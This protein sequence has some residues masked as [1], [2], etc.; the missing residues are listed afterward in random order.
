MLAYLRRDVYLRLCIMIAAWDSR[1]YT[2]HKLPACFRRDVLFHFFTTIAA[3]G[4]HFRTR[5]MKQACLRRDVVFLLFTMIAAKV[6]YATQ[7]RAFA[8]AIVPHRN[9][10]YMSKSKR[11]TQIEKVRL[12]FKILTCLERPHTTI[13]RLQA[14]FG[15]VLAYLSMFPVPMNN[16]KIQGIGQKEC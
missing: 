2:N 14:R 8:S 13:M 10:S 9:L 11:M 6:M 3:R 15:R 4:T 12:K 1:Q 5:Y 7:I 16:S